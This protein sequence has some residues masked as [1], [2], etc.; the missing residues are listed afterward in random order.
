MVP[1]YDYNPLPPGSIRLF[2]L[3][4]GSGNAPIEGNLTTIL[5]SDR[6]ATPSEFKALSYTWA[7]PLDEGNPFYKLYDT[8]QCY[9]LCDGKRMKVKENLNDALWQLRELK[10]SSLLWIDAV[11]INQ[12]DDE[13]IDRQLKLMPRIYSDAS[14]VVIW[15][16]KEDSLTYEAIQAIEKDGESLTLRSMMRAGNAFSRFDCTTESQS[17][18]MTDREWHVIAN[19]LLRTWFSRLWTLQEVLLPTRTTSFCGSRKVDISRAV[20]FAGIMLRNNEKNRAICESARPCHAELAIRRLGA[21]ASVAAWI[22]CAWPSGG[23][24][25][26][27]FLRYHKIDRELKIPRTFKW[28][29]ALEL[30]VHEARQRECSKLKDKIIAPLAFAI[31]EQ[32]VPDT[33]DFHCLETDIQNILDYSQSTE[34]LYCRFTH[35]MISSMANLDI[36]SRAHRNDDGQDRDL[37]LSLPSWVPPFHTAGSTSLIDDLLFTQYDAAK[38]LGRRCQGPSTDFLKLHVRA[39]FFGE[40]NQISKYIA[41]G[42]T[43]VSWVSSVQNSPD[44]KT[45]IEKE[46]SRDIASTVIQMLGDRIDQGREI[47]TSALEKRNEFLRA[48]LSVLSHTQLNIQVTKGTRRRLFCY[49]LGQG[50]LVG[51]APALAQERDCICILQGAKVPFIV[52]WTEQPGRFWLVG[53]AFVENF[54]YGELQS[55]NFSEQDIVFI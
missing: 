24:G 20:M 4:P 31:H 1:E 45:H 43:I 6:T 40:I 34:E 17:G 2:T 47:E 30:L 14:W 33:A 3:Q 53:E 13:E 7:N 16:G 10:D 5:L 29:V 21:A 42:D 37:E 11:C 39:I 54:M 48:W 52:R 35:F 8:V 26:R 9:I 32:Y 46:S 41:M 18:Y 27:A 28:L 22:G 12:T 44:Y 19:L 38:H 15:L 50:P 25:S 55:L 36:L 51:L 49:Y 23:F